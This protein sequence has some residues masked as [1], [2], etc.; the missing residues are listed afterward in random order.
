MKKPF[1]ESDIADFDEVMDVTG[2]K[3]SL[4]HAT[5]KTDPAPLSVYRRSRLF[6]QSGR[7][8]NR[9]FAATPTAMLRQDDASRSSHHLVSAAFLK[10]QACRPILQPGGI[11]A[12]LSSW[13]QRRKRFSNSHA[14]R[15]RCFF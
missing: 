15:D 9:F 12:P 3:T 5:E 14:F 8:M 4:G 7:E 10:D 13:L 6:R 1:E 11:F 2:G